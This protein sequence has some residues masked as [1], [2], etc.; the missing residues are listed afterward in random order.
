M[1]RGVLR[2]LAASGLSLIVALTA[3]EAV[4]RYFGRFDEDGM[5]LLHGH[6]I[7]PYRPPI[8]SVGR[9]L[10]AYLSEPRSYMAFDP[11]LGWTNRPGTKSQDGLY[12]ANSAGLR[13]NCDYAPE[14]PPGMLRIA[15]FGDSFVHGHD[16][17][18][19]GSLAPQLEE[20]LRRNGTLAEALNFGVG[21]YGIDQA[22]LRYRRE[23]PRLHPAIVLLGLQVENIERSVN[24]VRV[25]YFHDTGIPFTKPRFVFDGKDLRLVN[26][27]TVPVDQILD[28]LEHFSTSPLGRFE[29]FYRAADYEWLLYRRSR[30]L[31]SVVD[32]VRD[33]FGG[34]SGGARLLVPESDATKLTLATVER[35]RSEAKANGSRFLLVYLPIRPAIEALAAGHRDP[36]APLVDL[37]R[38]RFPLI[39]PSDLLS[40]EARRGSVNS[41]VLAHYT[42]VGN[43]LIAEAIARQMPHAAR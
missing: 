42:P 22:Y 29:H 37:F 12:R 20:V 8:H 2:S 40:A 6:R 19:A 13:A 41:I 34:G 24:V 10:H 27:P 11:D 7:R 33:R 31:A 23:G 39:D 17:P 35:F 15:I 14:S 18:L 32:I 5:F 26:S 36:Y 43:R 30:L 25:F 16:V 38:A 28:L 4:V 9:T 21:G 1:N 3:G